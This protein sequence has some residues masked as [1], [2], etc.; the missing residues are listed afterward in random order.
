ME[1]QLSELQSQL[2]ALT[3]EAKQLFAAQSEEVLL[4]RPAN[5]GWSAAECLEHLAKTAFNFKDI[6]DSAMKDAPKGKGPYK[7]DF[8]GRLLSWVL[9]PPF[10]LKVKTRPM[11][12]PQNVAS[13]KKAL[14]DFIAS[15]QMLAEYI[16]KTDGLALEQIM[17]QSP[18][19]ARIVYNLYSCFDIQV[20]HVMRHLV[21]ARNA[22]KQ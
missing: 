13:A 22:L 4:R 8:K 1:P 9:R 14:E 11:V 19:D 17:I 7:R 3:A 21:Q 5:G 12:E 16:G 20:S 2:N 10:W 18:F 15:Q 6:F